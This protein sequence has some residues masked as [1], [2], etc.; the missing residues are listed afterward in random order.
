MPPVAHLARPL[1][2]RTEAP[3]AGAGD[4][5]S[6]TF[7]LQP[8]ITVRATSPVLS[9]VQQ[10]CG[11]VDLATF[12]DAA[13]W[14]ELGEVS[15]PAGGTLSLTIESS[16]TWD[17]VNFRPVAP[18]LLLARASG[19]DGAVVPQ[20]I[21]CVRTPNTAPLSRWTRWRLTASSSATSWAATVRIRGTAGRTSF[22]QPTLLKDCA[23]WLRAD[24]GITLDA[25]GTSVSSWDDQS[26]HGNR[27]VTNPS[28]PTTHP[29][30][31]INPING[32]PTITFD[33]AQSQ[34]MWFNPSLPT[35]ITAAHAFVV[36]R[37]AASTEVTPLYTG[38]WKTVVG[39]D[40]AMPQVGSPPHIWDN[41]AST[42][43]ARDCGAVVIPSLAVPHVYE[44]A[45]GASGWTSRLNG[46]LQFTTATN[47]VWGFDA[48][49]VIGANNSGAPGPFYR[50]DWAEMVIYT[51]VLASAERALLIDYFN[52]RYGLGAG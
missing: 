17:E 37:R 6:R 20:L 18:P 43:P 33:A 32:Q 19:P 1:S 5:P 13:F 26:G 35:G 34:Y 10:D 39:T 36:H 14:V 22:F 3:N 23:V 45:S 30:Y 4:G 38:F 2:Q 41:F 7:L 47:T 11:W 42:S 15:P 48:N 49:A 51:R 44:A 46:T 28:V 31:D 12:A 40:V 21:R 16:P 27:V 25:N 29:T 8:W 52:G 9:V 50:G 24:L